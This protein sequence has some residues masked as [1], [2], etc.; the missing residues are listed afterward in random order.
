M[1][2]EMNVEDITAEIPAEKSILTKCLEINKADS[3]AWTTSTDT[4]PPWLQYN[5]C[6]SGELK[7][8]D[9][10]KDVADF[11]ARAF[12]FKAGKI[13]PRW[14][15][16]AYT[17]KTG[18]PCNRSGIVFNVDTW[19]VPFQNRIRFVLF[20][21]QQGIANDN[22]IISISKLGPGRKRIHANGRFNHLWNGREEDGIVQ[23]NRVIEKTYIHTPI[24]F[25][26]QMKKSRIRCTF[27]ASDDG[28]NWKKTG[29]L[30]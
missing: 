30:K 5:F 11:K 18:K 28:V 14:L 1:N 15:M 2:V 8:G 17:V 27:E 29:E 3:N 16:P 6:R 25:P 22:R 10:F 20:D 24:R 19:V 26:S 21:K 7:L 13:I 23:F 9:R 4:S 12:F